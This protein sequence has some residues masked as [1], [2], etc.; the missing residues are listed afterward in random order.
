M[1]DIGGKDRLN[2]EKRVTVRLS[3][4]MVEE[5][6]DLVNRDEY[7]SVSD[8]VR[9]AVSALLES[10]GVNSDFLPVQIMVPKNLIEKLGKDS[11]KPVNLSLDEFSSLI[12]DR[13]NGL[14]VRETIKKIVHEEN[15]K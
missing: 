4:S 9:K 11:T 13:I 8:L 7:E 6:E 1:S 5:M 14:T 2:D 15:I 10:R 12:L 3:R